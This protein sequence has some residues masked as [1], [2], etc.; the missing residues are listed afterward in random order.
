[1]QPPPGKDAPNPYARPTGYGRPPE[2]TFAI[3]PVPKVAAPP[4]RPAP[5][6]SSAILTGSAIPAAPTPRPA[7]P[8]PVPAP[9]RRQAEPAIEAPVFAAPAPARAKKTSRAPLIAGG[10]V[11]AIG[12]VA[13]ILLLGRETPAPEPQPEPSQPALVA[14]GEPTAI[15]PAPVAEEPAEAEPAPA[16]ETP[17]PVRAAR[18]ASPRRAV[19]PARPT[20]APRAEPVIAEPPP[21]VI[22]PV[23]TT[24]LP[25]VAEPAPLPPQPDPDAPVST[26]APEDR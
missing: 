4:P 12:A 10:A 22:P 7:P 20:P 6:R 15:Q 21:L 8:E 26:R 13:A 14:A 5:S 23:S 9:P 16:A 24:P 25:S 19:A 18:A 3:G 1:M 17:A 2:Q 11:M